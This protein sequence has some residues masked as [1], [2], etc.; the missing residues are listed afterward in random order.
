[1][2]A[3][4]LFRSGLVVMAV[5]AWLQ[6][7]SALADPRLPSIIGPNMV[8]QQGV[9]APIWG[10]AKP[11]EKVTVTFC[12]Q[13]VSAVAGADGLWLVRLAPLKAGGPFEM[14]IA[15]KTT[16][17]LKNVLVGE[18]W[19]GSGQSNMAMGLN[20]CSN[21]AA[22]AARADFPEL[23]LFRVAGA[24]SCGPRQDVSGSWVV[25]SPQTAGGF[26]GLAYFFGRDL[27]R[28]LKVPVGRRRPGCP[29]RRSGRTRISG[30]SSSSGRTR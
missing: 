24:T 12:G 28:R 20:G 10:W 21:G 6:G 29:S 7:P 26:S 16:L 18:V 15:G 11:G 17:V 8:L 30:R 4:T 3:K 2:R 1:M 5:A 9:E 27:H 22:E 25:C 23:R 19:L 14:T 13:E